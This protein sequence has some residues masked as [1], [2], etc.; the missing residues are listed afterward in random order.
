MEKTDAKRHRFRLIKAYRTTLG[1]I[2]SFGWI[3]LAGHVLGTKWQTQKMET[4]N[5]QNARHL[6]KTIMELK[7]LFIKVG[8]LLSIMSNFLPETFRNELE[9]LQDKI[10]SR[11][12]EEIADRI[13]SQLGNSPD[14]LFKSFNKTPVASASL[15][16]VHEA[17]LPDGRRVAVKVQYMDIDKIAR[18]DLKTIHRIL[19]IVGFLF[20]I[21]GINTNFQ[22]IKEMILEELNFTKEGK[23]IETIAAN[24]K[25]DTDIKFPK[26]IHGYSTQK[27]LTTEFMEGVKVTN[28]AYLKKHGI[29][30]EALANRIITAYCRMI[31]TDGIYHADPHPGNIL[32]QT[33][34]SV[35]FVDFGAV[36]RLSPAM[37]EGI[38]QFLEGVLKR[39]KVQI[40]DAL[41]LMGFIAY[42][43]HG[44]EVETIIDYIYGRFLE[45]LS[46]DSW[47]LK[48][49]RIGIEARMEMISDFRKLNISMRDLMVEFHIPKDWVLLERTVILLMG[50]CTYLEPKMNPMKTIKPYLETFVLGP[51]RNWKTFVGSIFKDMA[52]A[53][54]KMPEEINKLLSKTNQGKLEFQIN[55]VTQGAQLLYVLGH[56]ILWGLFSMVSGVMAYISYL[57][58]ESLLVDWFAGASAFFIICLVTSMWRV[59]KKHRKRHREKK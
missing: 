45:E 11:P 52:V 6:K 28:L 29:D 22:Q 46:F 39:N 13:H 44:Y 48:D 57:H 58:G 14:I 38:P 23:H 33:N 56:Q 32:V 17:Y 49:I 7:G 10:S 24:F 55:N 27:I 53:A 5:I 50:L 18:Q 37:K 3:K 15:A 54:F 26:V 20:Q 43:S 35:V 59:N 34:G 21:K 19:G 41:R 40:T 12:Y 42:D 47:N 8:Q 2:I 31:F 36:A 30:R 4:A 1:I 51:T 25:D 16:Q 9:G